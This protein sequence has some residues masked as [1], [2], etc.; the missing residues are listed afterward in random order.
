[1]SRQQRR[2]YLSDFAFPWRVSPVV[3]T[4]S[5]YSFLAFYTFM[6][7]MVAEVNWQRGIECS[8]T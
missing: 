3:F 5:A 8:I 6:I 4:R 1:M 2:A 7:A